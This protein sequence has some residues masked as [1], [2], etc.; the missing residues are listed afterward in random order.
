MT[1]AYDQYDLRHTTSNTFELWFEN[2]DSTIT[3]VLLTP[4]LWCHITVTLV[5]DYETD[6]KS[7]IAIVYINGIQDL[8]SSVSQ[9]KVQP[10]GND[11][12]FDR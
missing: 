3:T 8:T 12:T 1:D 9:F 10:N 6:L 5:T 11:Q 4:E 2:G 7:G